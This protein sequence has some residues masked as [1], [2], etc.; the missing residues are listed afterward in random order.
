MASYVGVVKVAK[1]SPQQGDIERPVQ[2]EYQAVGNDVPPKNSWV[3]RGL[4]LLNHVDK[5]T[6]LLL[7]WKGRC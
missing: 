3:E 6:W 5:V 7:T 4:L 1:V 2:S